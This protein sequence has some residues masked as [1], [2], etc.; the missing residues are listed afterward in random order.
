MHSKKIQRRAV[1]FCGRFSACIARA[2]GSKAVVNRLFLDT[3]ALLAGFNSFKTLTAISENRRYD[4]SK[5]R[6]DQALQMLYT[7]TMKKKKVA[8]RKEGYTTTEMREITH[9]MIDESAERL[10][11]RLRVAWKKQASEEK[12]IRH[13]VAV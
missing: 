11:L 12:M 9:R 1:S 5:S 8:K 10:R 3:S 6:I 4:K 13:G 7:I 2:R